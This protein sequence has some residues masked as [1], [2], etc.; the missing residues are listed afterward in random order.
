VI[1]L[2]LGGD[3]VACYCVSVRNSDTQVDVSAVEAKL[4]SMEKL[5]EL[6]LKE[7]AA[8]SGSWLSLS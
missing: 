8:V 2:Y 3:L 6:L 1:V 7:I 4:A 5:A